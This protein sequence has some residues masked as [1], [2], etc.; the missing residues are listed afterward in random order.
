MTFAEVLGWS[1]D[2]YSFVFVVPAKVFDNFKY[3]KSKKRAKIP[4]Y[5]ITP[6]DTE[7]SAWLSKLDEHMKRVLTFF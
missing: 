3:M 2:T 7:K 4:Q 6:V 5:A 1:T